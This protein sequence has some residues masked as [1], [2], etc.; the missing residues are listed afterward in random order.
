[1]VAGVGILYS[2]LFNQEIRTYIPWLAIGLVFW[3]Y[4]SS[5]I[6]EGCDSL[7]FSSSIIKQTSLPVITFIF[8]TIYRNLIVLVHQAV[9]LVAVI[10]FF[11]VQHCNV[12]LALVGVVLATVNLAWM[13]LVLSIV[14]A[15]FRDVP[16][17]IV[18]VMQLLLFLTPVFWRPEGI[19]SHRAIL[20]A[21]PLYHMLEVTRRPLIGEMP[22]TSSYVTLLIAAGVGLLVT[23]V[24]FARSRRR[25]VHFL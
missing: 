7:I 14:S 20:T 5:S 13:A 4:F 10:L 19:N 15:R 16:Q 3:Q 1:M 17:V 8:R 18:S 23:L 11:R 25:V 24:L 9:V 12:L 21:N 2:Q 6:V 22:A